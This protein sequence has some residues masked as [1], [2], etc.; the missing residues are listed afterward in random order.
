MTTFHDQIK[1]Q[2]EIAH[3]EAEEAPF[4]AS[5][6]RGTLNPTAYRDYLSALLPIY[7]AM[8]AHFKTSD[9]QGLLGPFNQS[10]LYRSSQIA[11]DIAHIENEFDL[12]SAPE[13][14]KATR[15]YLELL[16]EEIS[17]A[18]LLAH[19]YIRYLGDLSG[20]QAIAKL[21]GRHYQ[22]PAEG[23][24]FYDFSGI[25]DAVE[26]KRNYRELL[27]SELTDAKDQS[28]FLDEVKALY[29]LSRDIFLELGETHRPIKDQIRV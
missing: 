9:P 2:T 1:S 23:L 14:P 20:G 12:A 3:A 13:I 15:A 22:I 24:N 11:Q 18:R 6:M 27:N 10:A 29:A 7:E 4:V 5:L 28:D 17:E 25:D 8:E 21:V 19:H 16:D 26:F